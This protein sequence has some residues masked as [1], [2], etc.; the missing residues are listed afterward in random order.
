MVVSINALKLD[1]QAL[2][3]FTIHSFTHLLPE[4]EPTM[5]FHFLCFFWHDFLVFPTCVY[6]VG[7][8]NRKLGVVPEHGGKR[9]KRVSQQRWVLSD[10]HRTGLHI[11]STIR[12]LLSSDTSYAFLL[13]CKLQ[14]MSSASLMFFSCF[15]L[16]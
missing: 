5:Y 3:F 8:M 10:F 13:D 14:S 9:E 15:T 11:Q 12:I 7:L 2:Y 16:K 4:M 6:S 1:V